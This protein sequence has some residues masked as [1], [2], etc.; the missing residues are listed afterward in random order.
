MLLPVNYIKPRSPQ[1]T[2]IG[3][4]EDKNCQVHQW[5]F[6]QILQRKRRTVIPKYLFDET[7]LVIIRLPLHLKMR[8][9]VSVLI[10]NYKH[11]LMA[12]SDFTLFWIPARYS[13]ISI[14]KIRYNI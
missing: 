11:L 5:H 1:W 8:N 14:M 10:V 12:N 9:L 6:F 3:T 13:L 4:K 2:L 7:K